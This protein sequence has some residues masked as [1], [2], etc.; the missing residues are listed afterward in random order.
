MNKNKIIKGLE[1]EIESTRATLSDEIDSET[2]DKLSTHY[3]K[4]LTRYNEIMKIDSDNVN[5]IV[6]N[7]LDTALFV[8]KVALTAALIGAMVA[9]EKEGTCRSKVWNSITRLYS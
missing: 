6:K 8:G 9:I 4:L 3:D 2:F 5:G 1:E 7:G